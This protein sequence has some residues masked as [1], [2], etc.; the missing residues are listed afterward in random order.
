MDVDLEDRRQSHAQAGTND[1]TVSIQP[2]LSSI[3]NSS[4]N[5]ASPAQPE[6]SAY[7]HGINYNSSLNHVR[8]SH[9]HF[10]ENGVTSEVQ[11]KADSTEGVASACEAE[12]PAQHDPGPL[13]MLASA[14]PGW[15]CYAEKTHGSYIL[16]F[17]STTKSPQVSMP[18][19]PLT[20][21]FYPPSPPHLPSTLLP[22]IPLY[23]AVTEVT[24]FVRA[25]IVKTLPVSALACTMHP[26]ATGETCLC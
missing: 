15:V 23:T 3:S 11:Q 26:A 13:P 21:L 1:S 4:H 5:T 9:S 10:A 2:F 12:T 7:S 24:L 18:P 8:Q 6:T 25:E 19:H 20:S 14:C 17:I 16:P 22:P